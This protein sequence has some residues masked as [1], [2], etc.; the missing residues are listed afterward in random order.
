MRNQNSTE[1]NS[2]FEIKKQPVDC[3]CGLFKINR[4][5]FCDFSAAGSCYEKINARG[6]RFVGRPDDLRFNSLVSGLPVRF[7]R[8]IFDI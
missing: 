4:A 2:S 8:V 7:T 5:F 6:N 3:G 1:G